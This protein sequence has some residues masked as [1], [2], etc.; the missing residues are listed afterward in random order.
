MHSWTQ[1]IQ[2][3]FWT[4]WKHITKE[5]LW[6]IK[7]WPKVCIRTRGFGE[8]AKNPS[9]A[10]HFVCKN[11]TFR[12]ECCPCHEKWHSN[13]TKYWN[14]SHDW[15]S[16]HIRHPVQRA[17]Q[18]EQQGTD[19]SATLKLLCKS[20]CLK[21]RTQDNHLPFLNKDWKSLVLSNYSSNPCW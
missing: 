5:M 13:F 7:S 19:W 3:L 1:N 6:L 20:P 17:E 8:L 4:T 14:D 15:S 11:T 16:S 21:L 2:I 12:A 10:T 9:W 18:Q